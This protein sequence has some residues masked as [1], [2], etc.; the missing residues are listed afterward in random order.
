MNTDAEKAATGALYC[1]RDAT[2]CLRVLSGLTISNGLCWSPDG[3]RFYHTDSWTRRIDTYDY[4]LESGGISNQHTLTQIPETDGCP[5]GMTIDTHGN[6]WVAL[7]GGGAVVCLDGLN[8]EELARVPLPVT[9]VTSCTF[10]GN[11]L[12]ELFIT[13]AA[14][15]L[16]A[17][18]RAAQPMAG[19]V[20]RARPGVKGLPLTL[21]QI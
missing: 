9:Q 8:G 4:N 14:V 7:W 16:T 3:S 10:G 15:S 2:T 13:T 6:L 1:C 12:D 20:F 17:Q 21:G 5:D 19:D 11:A 18:A